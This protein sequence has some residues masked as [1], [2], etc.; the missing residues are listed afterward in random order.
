MN[1]QPSKKRRLVADTLSSSQDMESELNRTLPKCGYKSRPVQTTPLTEEAVA[2]V[3]VQPTAVPTFDGTSNVESQGV[4]PDG[5]DYGVRYGGHQTNRFNKS[6]VNNDEADA[7]AEW[8]YQR[9]RQSAQPAVYAAPYTTSFL[10]QRTK[11]SLLCVLR[12]LPEREPGIS[13]PRSY[14][15]DYGT[16]GASS[17]GSYFRFDGVFGATQCAAKPG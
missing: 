4:Y 1:K 7:R 13:I 8:R 2:P 11:Q 10:P 9:H 14:R 3:E 6:L 16:H 17:G 5:Y 12:R 15:G